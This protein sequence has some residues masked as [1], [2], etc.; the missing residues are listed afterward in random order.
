MD[1]PVFSNTTGAL[2]TGLNSLTEFSDLSPK[3]HRLIF[4]FF[5]VEV[6]SVRTKICKSWNNA[7]QAAVK[8]VKRIWDLRLFFLSLLELSIAH[9]NHPLS[10]IPELTAHCTN[11]W[12]LELYSVT[13]YNRKRL[14]RSYKFKVFKCPKFSCFRNEIIGAALAQ[15]AISFTT[16]TA[17]ELP[18]GDDSSDSEIAG[19]ISSN[20]QRTALQIGGC[21]SAK[22][23]LSLRSLEASTTW[24]ILEYRL[25][26]TLRALEL[27]RLKRLSEDEVISP[28][29]TRLRR[30]P[31]AVT[32]INVCR[33]YQHT[34][35]SI[36]ELQ[37]VIVAY[38]TQKNLKTLSLSRHESTS[39][40][41]RFDK[42]GIH[43]QQL[44]LVH[45]D[46]QGALHAIE[47]TPN[48][49]RLDL[50]ESY[51][52]SSHMDKTMSSLPGDLVHLSVQQC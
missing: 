19:V 23:S 34:V 12:V 36:P 43:I 10:S 50:S 4:S 40:F 42:Y 5:D 25:A 49:R 47:N 33:E 17:G 1:P 35:F 41:P 44:Q 51:L 20:P 3:L 22:T 38:L 14:K 13:A 30:Q 52:S 39:E 31:T 28:M 26:Q 45:T 15:L 9:Q 18:D 46:I 37:A 27:Y 11:L 8:N 29:K 6:L 7:R 2:V 32:N 24:Y 48:L 16:F 21:D